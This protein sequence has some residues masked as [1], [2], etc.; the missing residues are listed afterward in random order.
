MGDRNSTAVKLRHFCT[1][2]ATLAVAL[3]SESFMKL[4]SGRR[5]EGQNGRFG[6]PEALLDLQTGP[7]A[8]LARQPAV[9][10]PQ[11]AVKMSL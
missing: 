10:S 7:G 2:E 1:S 3:D 9:R 6:E 8:E 11:E 4:A 5:S